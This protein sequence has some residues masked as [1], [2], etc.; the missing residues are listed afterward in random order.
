MAGQPE[1]G[2]PPDEFV[3][4]SGTYGRIRCLRG[5]TPLII[6][7]NPHAYLS[8]EASTYPLN[9]TWLEHAFAG[10]EELHDRCDAHVRAAAVIGTGAGLDTIGI[11]H[12]FAPDRIVASDLHPRV[13]DTA[14]WNVAAYARR[15]TACEVIGSDLFRQYPPQSRFDLVYE[16]LPNV[17]DG[18]DLF[19]GIRAASCF[20]PADYRHDSIGDRYLLTL[21][22]NLLVE[23]RDHLEPG[24]W[25]VATI[26]GRVPW[27]VIAD[28]F[29]RAGFRAS[30]LHFGI[31]IQSE[32]DVVL[33]GYAN[34][35]RNGSPPFIYYH[36]AEICA[37]TLA[38]E[39]AAQNDH[40]ER[41][42]ERVNAALDAYR[43]SG[44]DALMRHQSGERV[45][46][47]VYIVG[48]TPMI[49]AGRHE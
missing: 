38:R 17:P 31:K 40:S 49:P 16:N 18:S 1:G 3:D 12:L 47:S 39:A 26:G 6:K 23:A 46:H 28:L 25:V 8:V 4:V 43:I 41:W 14:R 11:S 7:Q 24:G 21:H 48:G 5:L 19:S 42:V 37:S 45:L 22:Y 29:A 44:R 33:E 32:P 2:S 36:S 9:V 10:M 15:E 13:L 20:S 35:E 27:G 34:A 30:V